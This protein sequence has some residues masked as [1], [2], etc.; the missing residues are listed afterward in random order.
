VF[1]PNPKIDAVPIVGGQVCY[2]IDDALREPDRWVEYSQTHR[3]AFSM[4]PFNAYPGLEFHL[5]A[6]MS[7]QLDDFFRLHIRRLMRARRTLQMYS[8]LSLVTLQPNELMPIQW[9]CHRDRMGVP[10]DQCVAAS[11]LYLFKDESLG[12]TS[13]FMP[14]RDSEETEGLMRSAASAL[15]DAF[16]A[17]IGIR[18]GYL[19]ESNAYFERVC[20]VHAR[21][22]RMIFYDGSLF[23]SPDI[24]EPQKL[25][26][27]P[28]IGRL[29]MN[30]FYTCSRVA[31]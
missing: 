18:P 1:N 28:T 21:W 14:K 13:F 2:V 6:S 27:D 23:H 26:P 24:R 30:G 7:A 5:P 22:N 17:E 10:P 16:A 31:S 15:P 3:D 12:G 29:T 4:A 11:V 9:L 19:I 20:T 25:N 8:R